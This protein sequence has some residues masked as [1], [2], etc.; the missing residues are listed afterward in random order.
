MCIV[1]DAIQP[2]QPLPPPSPAL[3]LS[4]PEPTLP[5]VEAW[6]LNHWTAR[7]VPNFIQEVSEFLS[8]LR[9]NYISL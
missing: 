3:D 7:E 2:S 1:G 4:L 8:F 5:A 9:M 6:R